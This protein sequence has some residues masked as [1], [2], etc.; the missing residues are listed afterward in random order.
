MLATFAL[1]GCVLLIRMLRRIGDHSALTL[2]LLV[3]S[4]LP[5]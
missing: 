2:A 3:L 4:R 1:R 5:A